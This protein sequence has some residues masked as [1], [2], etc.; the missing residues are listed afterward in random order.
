MN[1]VGQPGHHDNGGVAGSAHP[2]SGGRCCYSHEF[3]FRLV[4]RIRRRQRECQN[5]EEEQ[6]SLIQQALNSEG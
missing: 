3:Y 4:N 6:L 2:G 5:R 1:G